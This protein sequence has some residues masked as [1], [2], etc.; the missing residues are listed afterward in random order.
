MG[1]FDNRPSR[2]PSTTDDEMP[3][4][5]LSPRRADEMPVRICAHPGCNAPAGRMRMCREHLGSER[6]AKPVIDRPRLSKRVID[7]PRLKVQNP[8]AD[9][10]EPADERFTWL[11]RETKF[12]KEMQKYWGHDPIA[13]L[14][15]ELVERKQWNRLVQTFW[16]DED[17]PTEAA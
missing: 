5:R 8:K 7:R 4:R 2:R 3:R 15:A 10:L 6:V 1:F 13:A 12:A 17:E 11:L 14:G 9:A 16:P